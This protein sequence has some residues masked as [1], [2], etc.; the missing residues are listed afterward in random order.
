M[1]ERGGAGEAPPA[2]G[3]NGLTKRRAA[4]A[5]GDQAQRSAEAAGG[6]PKG[7]KAIPNGGKRRFNEG[8][9]TNAYSDGASQYE[10]N[11][12]WDSVT[13]PPTLSVHFIIKT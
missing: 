8:G 3:G 12:G 1:V 5:N 6:Y 4:A 9:G 7:S 13:R 2:R 10:V 11:S